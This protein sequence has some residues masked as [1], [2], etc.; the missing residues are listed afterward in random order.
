[1]TTSEGSPPVPAA[2]V[3]LLRPGSRGS[4]VLLIHRPGTMTF[5]PGLHVFPGGKVDPEDRD[6]GP[7]DGLAG[8]EAADRLGGNLPAG[9]ALAVHRA[10]VREV[11]EEIGVALRPGDLVPVA[12]WTTPPFMPRRFET[13]FFVA[14]LPRGVEPVFA[15]DEVAAHRWLTPADALAALADGEIDMWV[16]TTSV[17]EQLAAVRPDR[18]DDVGAAVRFGSVEAPHVTAETSFGVRIATSAAGAVPG[19]SAEIVLLGRREVIVVDPGDPSEIAIA[20]ILAAIDR[21]GG[22]LRGIVLGAPDPDHA[23]GA[24]ALAIPAEVPVF[25]APGAGRHLPYD[26][27]EVRDGEELP[28]DVRLVV[29]LGPPG[30][31]RLLVEP[32]S[33]APLSAG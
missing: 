33:T 3:A 1:M 6:R 18:A 17:L 16:P 11:A 21:R 2:T 8:G 12:Q 32:V 29:R 23:A 27:V 9:D 30:S 4:E 7:D 22:R 5:G 19:R 15:P 24:E 10:A 20:A 13:W 31:G 25:V 26:T 14:D 28:S